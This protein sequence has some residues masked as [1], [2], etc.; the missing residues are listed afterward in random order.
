MV[1]SAVELASLVKVVVVVVLVLVD[2]LL[3]QAHFLQMESLDLEH[4]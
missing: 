2:L 3:M 4:H 1:V